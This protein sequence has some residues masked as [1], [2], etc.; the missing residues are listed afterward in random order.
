MKNLIAPKLN[1]YL[2]VLGELNSGPGH[3]SDY[4]VDQLSQVGS[5]QDALDEYFATHYTNLSPPQ[6]AARWGIRVGPVAT[7]WKR[8]V[9]EAAMHWFFEQAFSPKVSYEGVKSIVV[10]RFA[11]LMLE[12]LGEPTVREVFVT[13]SMF[14]EIEWQDFALTNG[15]GRWLLHFGWSD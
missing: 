8:A 13:P 5:L 15:A 3:G 7:D 4:S 14:Y 9:S 6:P 1:I 10:E 2:E 11:E 12:E